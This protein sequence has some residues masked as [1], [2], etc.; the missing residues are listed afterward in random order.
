MSVILYNKLVR[1]KVPEQIEHTGKSCD[2]VVAGDD[3]YCA[4]LDRK[5]DEEM[6]A[7]QAHH[8]ADNLASLVELIHAA[9]DARGWSWE[10]LE[11]LRL[12]KRALK[13]GYDRHLL[14]RQIEE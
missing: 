7:Y 10:E 3:Q 1:D 4:L 8:S 6:A 9:A 12:E 13:G 11:R 2:V 14:L 5:L